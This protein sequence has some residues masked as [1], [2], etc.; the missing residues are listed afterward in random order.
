MLPP[1]VLSSTFHF[2]SP[3][4]DS[5][6]VAAEGGGL[7]VKLINGALVILVTSVVTLNKDVQKSSSILSFA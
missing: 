6:D 2:L 4:G 3:T 1:Y 5:K 7:P